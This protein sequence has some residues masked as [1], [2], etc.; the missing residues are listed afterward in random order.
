M[1]DA[2]RLKIRG[3]VESLRYEPAVDLGDVV[4]GRAPQFIQDPVEFFKRT[5][6]TESMKALVVKVIMNLIGL[7][8]ASVGGRRYEARSSLILLPS[9]LG[10]G[11]THSL[12]LLYHVFNLIRESRSKD[13]AASKLRML[14]SDIAGFVH[15]KWDSIRSSPPNLVFIDCKYSDLAP[16]PAK[17]IE[18]GG[19]KIKTIWG[20]L[21]HVLGRYDAVRSSDDMETAPYA[22]ALL[23]VLDRSRAVVLIDEIG[24]YYDQSGLEPT[25]ISA[26]LM[27]LA[28]ALSKYNVREVTVVITMPYEIR[29]GPVEPK[30]GMEYIHRRELV[31]AIGSVLSRANVDIIKPVGERE[32]AEILRKRI[33]AYEREE[34]DRMASE[35]VSSELGREYPA[36]V[37]KILDDKGFWG[38]ARKTYPFHP[39]FLELVE[40][41]AYRLPHLQRTRDAIKIAVQAVLALRE[42]LFDAVEDEVGLVMPYHIPVFVRETLDETILR[43]PPDEYMVFRLVLMENV[44]VPESFDN[45]KKLGKEGFYEKV[46]ARNLRGLGQEREGLGFKLASII[47]LHSLV[48][49]GLPMNLGLYPTTQDLI[50]SVSP[51]DQDI[52][53]TLGILRS[54]LPQLIVHGDPESDSAKWFFT[55]IPSIEELVE[56]LKKNV[57]DD[58]AKNKLKELLE[59]GLSGKKGKGRPPKGYKEDSIFTVPPASDIKSIPKDYLERRDPVLLVLADRVSKDEMLNLLKGRNNIVVLAPHVDG[60]G[61]AKELAPEDI[62]GIRELAGLRGRTAWD[63]LMEMLRYY[64][65]AGSI[66]EDHLKAMVGEKLGRGEGTYIEDLLSVLKEKVGSK[67]EYYERHSWTMINRCYRRV[68]YYRQGE[69]R[70]EEG[71]SLE[72]DKPIPVVVEDFLR[73]KGLIPQEFTKDSI[74]SIVRDYLGRDPKEEPIRVG[75][76][77]SFITTTDKANT[78]IIRYSDFINAV[79]DLIKTEDYAVKAGGELVWKPIFSSR[80]ETKSSGE[81]EKILE[82]VEDLLKRLNISWDDVELVYWEKAFDEWLNRISKSIPSNKVVKVEDRSGR[83]LDIRDIRLDLKNTVKAGKLFYEE[84]KYPVEISCKLPDRVLEGRE[85]EVEAS[86]DVK[87]FEGEIQ[88]KLKPDEGLTVEP[89]EF[90]GEPPLSARFKIKGDKAGNYIIT[91]DVYGRDGI[92]DSRVISVQVIGEWIEEEIAIDTAGGGKPLGDDAKVVSIVVSEIAR[93]PEI[94]KIM[95]AH[96]GAVAGFIEINSEATKISL[97]IKTEDHAVLDQLYSTIVNIFRTSGAKAT[98]ETTYTPKSELELRR[99]D[100]LIVNKEG[101]RF[102]IKKRANTG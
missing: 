49:L 20:Y 101:M 13:E 8:E 56:T 61:E 73:D 85:Y 86:I 25:K 6:L 46:V 83:V 78:P 100:E 12:I 10:G 79:K 68:Y 89:R 17:P 90:S 47:W 5:H 29:G 70:F 44:A 81:G 71:L 40:K 22:D 66:G 38:E 94:A 53:G 2:K 24:R 99:I 102:K 14:D 7:K 54:T 16:S 77:W 98:I 97:S 27:N 67:K 23:Q 30:P 52:K 4:K 60:I 62:S 63:G 15:E 74:L 65:A 45:I 28:E 35:F 33:F 82:K 34:L 88:V 93:L 87:N 1:I 84:K 36:H 55:N 9:D 50:Y 31:E 11:K 26:F 95:R 43:S 96:G 41:L 48:G 72:S 19:R 37:K 42:G 92:L 32:I 59:S 3:E 18:I 91:A 51:T 69:V 80:E 76:L 57:T 75:S 64:I 39:M 58:M 21:G